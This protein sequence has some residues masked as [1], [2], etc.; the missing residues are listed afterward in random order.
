MKV[1]LNSL[2]CKRPFFADKNKRYIY[3]PFATPTFFQQASPEAHAS[4]A[5][6][7]CAMTSSVMVV[8]TEN[9][10]CNQQRHYDDV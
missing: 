8:D 7:T 4:P 3:T 5:H 6:S 1:S 10:T 2:L 9:Q